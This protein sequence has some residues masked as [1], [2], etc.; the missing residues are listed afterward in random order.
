MRHR[1]R[2]PPAGLTPAGRFRSGCRSP[3]SPV[4]PGPCSWPGSGCERSRICPPVRRCRGDKLG[5]SPPEP[6]RSRMP[7]RRERRVS[8]G[9]ILHHPCG[10]DVA[11]VGTAY[12]GGFLSGWASRRPV[13]PGSAAPGPHAGSTQHLRE[14]RRAVLSAGGS[15]SPAAL[16][17]V[18]AAMQP[19]CGRCGRGEPITSDA[20][21]AKLS[22]ALWQ[23]QTHHQ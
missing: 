16:R 7:A 14:K 15:G 19:R 4:P 22:H 20:M 11:W 8:D 23:M 5:T 1:P 12:P 21:D 6:A 18:P 17:F 3:P 13:L 9:R 10:V 2:Y